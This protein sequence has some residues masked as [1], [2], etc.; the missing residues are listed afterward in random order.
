MSLARSVATVATATLAS[1]LLG[2]VRDVAI[3][4]VLGAG[5]FSDAFLAALQIPNLFRRLLAEGALNSAFVP[6][7]L[8]IREDRGIDGARR[9]GERVLGTMVVGLGVIA[10]LSVVFAPEVVH[11]LAP[12]FR[13]SG[14][15]FA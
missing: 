1:R 9:F 7:W 14:E 11:L 15:R 5:V 3:S 10:L 12:G 4:G 6:T 8:R 2:F 13:V